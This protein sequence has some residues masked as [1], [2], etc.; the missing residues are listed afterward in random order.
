MTAYIK[1]LIL[2]LFM[3][4]SC[5]HLG[6]TPDSRKSILAD[7]A[8]IREWNELSMT[9]SAPLT[10]VLLATRANVIMHLA[11]HDALN[12]IDPRYEKYLY[13][14]TNATANAGAAV[15]SAAYHVLKVCFPESE[16]AYL[17][18]FNRQLSSIKNDDRKT[19]GIALGKDVAETI[20]AARAGD[21][22][23]GD[24]VSTIEP[25]NTP[26]VYQTVPP[27]NFLY[28]AD[29]ITVK[30]F[31]LTSQNQFRCVPPPALTS[32]RYTTDYNEVAAIGK[33]SSTTRTNIQTDIVKFWYEFS[34]IGW[35][36][37]ARRAIAERKLGAHE[38][39]RL[40][41]LLNIGLMDAYLAG[42]D[43]KFHYN[44]WR[45][46]TAILFAANDGNPATAPI[47][48]WASVLPTPPVQ[49]YPSTHSA[50]GN[51]GATILSGILGESVAFST[52]SSSFENEAYV[53]AFSSFMA[54]A[55]E[56]AESRILGGLHFR[57][58]CQ[59]G[60]QLG[61]AI[62]QWILANQLR[63]VQNK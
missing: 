49:D 25:S 1:L 59:A 37:I 42:W 10:H 43:S 46:H 51:A 4:V 62:G 30:P 55:D 18:L 38:T 16:P 57:F 20:L 29:W 2:A 63:P 13:T 21:N 54:A 22:A 40:F 31:G 53:K 5:E 50:L 27:M 3:S 44:L 33:N 61:N 24:P 35:N 60:Q 15:A 34:E 48:N 9:S 11:I 14:K 32:E 12:A 8:V 23:F 58:S 6:G 19:A 17:E 56:N 52:V 36:R 39:A 26:G 7:P 45:P 28:G 41:A 47:E